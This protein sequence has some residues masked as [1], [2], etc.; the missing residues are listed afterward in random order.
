MDT[1]IFIPGRSSERYTFLLTAL[2]SK[3][4]MDTQQRGHLQNNKTAE[5]SSTLFQG[6]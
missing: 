4:S 1:Y 5:G 3:S 2:S 6:I